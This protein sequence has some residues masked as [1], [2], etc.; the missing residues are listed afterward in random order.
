M[1]ASSSLGASALS[2]SQRK[3]EGILY[4]ES[5][6]F[7]EGKNCR[8]RKERRPS[9]KS[10]YL[11]SKRD[12]YKGR[13]RRSSSLVLV[14]DT[15][16]RGRLHQTPKDHVLKSICIEDVEFMACHKP[17]EYMAQ[18]SDLSEPTN[19]QTLGFT[20]VVLKLLPLSICI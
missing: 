14:K 13:F 9:H 1:V 7:S 19:K 2:L 12:T 5:R 10:P 11:A 15:Q 8:S 17:T 3:K 4:T 20:N 6:G 16:E 18:M